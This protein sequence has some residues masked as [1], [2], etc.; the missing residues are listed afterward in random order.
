M[1]KMETYLSVVVFRV[2]V[3]SHVLEDICEVPV[4][5]VLHQQVL[6]DDTVYEGLRFEHLKI[7]LHR[8]VE[9]T[10]FLVTPGFAQPAVEVLINKLFCL[11]ISVLLDSSEGNN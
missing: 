1:I 4:A 2:R 10:L 7:D 9:R 8:L 5:L 3:C 6:I 11:L